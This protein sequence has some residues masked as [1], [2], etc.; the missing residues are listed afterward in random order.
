MSL[1]SYGFSVVVY[2]APTG[3]D[4]GAS[5]ASN[6]GNGGGAGGETTR[7]EET[8]A[9]I[10]GGSMSSLTGS[11]TQSAG[12][13]KQTGSAATRTYTGHDKMAWVLARLGGLCV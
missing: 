1:A 6:G 12:N 4:I 8:S 13:L 5:G 2:A 10:A 9:F 3:T 11:E 7:T